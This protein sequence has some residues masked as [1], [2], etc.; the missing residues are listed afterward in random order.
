VQLIIFNLTTGNPGSSLQC[1]FQ[2]HAHTWI[3]QRVSCWS[4]L[5]MPGVLSARLLQLWLK[6]GLCWEKKYRRNSTIAG[7]TAGGCH[8]QNAS[9]LFVKQKSRRRAVVGF[10]GRQLR[11]V[12]ALNAHQQLVRCLLPLSGT[13]ESKGGAETSS[14]FFPQGLLSNFRSLH[15][16][17]DASTTH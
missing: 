8:N 3:S 2:T 10:L 13:F 16:G 15:V 12:D 1:L 14:Y 11:A 9:S 7:Y 6:P 5:S 17:T 4:A